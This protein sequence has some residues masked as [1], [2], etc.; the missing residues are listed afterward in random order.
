MILLQLEDEQIDDDPVAQADRIEIQSI[1]ATTQSEIDRR[2]SEI[3]ELREIIQMQAD[4]R[5]GVAIGAAGLAQMI[6]SDAI[7]V[8]EREK[9]KLLQQEWEGKLR[10][11]E[12][13]LSMERAR[14]ARERVL[15][16]QERAN[17]ISGL[18]ENENDLG[19]KERRWLKMLGLG[20]DGQ[21]RR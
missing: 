2:D 19:K 15:V 14:L 12:I 7:I 5:D 8:Q 17:T 20:E 21:N 10:Q 9:L 16:E 4:A 13:D 3:E 18:N 6:D 11:A 1:I